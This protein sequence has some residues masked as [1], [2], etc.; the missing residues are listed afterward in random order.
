MNL[1]ANIGARLA[2]PAKGASDHAAVIRLWSLGEAENHRFIVVESVRPA[3]HDR[4]Y[5]IAWI[6]DV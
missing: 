5:K 2:I 3:E 1:A 6:V 4:L